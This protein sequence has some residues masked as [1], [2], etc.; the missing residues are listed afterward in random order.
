MIDEIV[1][2]PPEAA[3]LGDGIAPVDPPAVIN[4]HPLIDCLCTL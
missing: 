4:V 3:I 1:A 2:D